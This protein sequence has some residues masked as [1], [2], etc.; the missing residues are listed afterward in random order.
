MYLTLHLF[1]AHFLADY[2]LQPS[3]IVKMKYKSFLGVFIHTVIHL[4]VII[5]LSIPFLHLP[6]VWYGIAI[7][8]VTH[9]IIDYSKVTIEKKFKKINHLYSYILDQALHLTI[10]YSVAVFLMGSIQPYISNGWYE[11]YS[12]RYMVG[13]ALILVLVTYVY[14]V[15]RWIV[16]NYKKPYPYKRD[17]QTMYRNALI[18]VIAFVVYCFTR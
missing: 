5:L 9:N 13:F 8:F 7:I 4:A 15:T 3:W 10:I 11:F 2:P 18:V 14:D 1:L 6:N 17:Y 12:N 16:M